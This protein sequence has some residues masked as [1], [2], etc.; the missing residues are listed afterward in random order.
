MTRRLLSAA[1]L[2]VGVVGVAG[3][4]SAAASSDDGTVAT[5]GEL[6]SARHY[7]CLETP[8]AIE[9]PHDQLFHDGLRAEVDA[10]PGVY[11]A[12]TGEQDA[13]ALAKI[14]SSRARPHW[15]T[16]TYVLREGEDGVTVEANV[17]VG[18][19]PDRAIRATLRGSAR[20]Q[21]PDAHSRAIAGAIEATLRRLP[22]LLNVQSDPSAY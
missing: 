11:L 6:A 20:A 12:P 10:R 8:S 4:G 7:V 17:I 21:G 3:C 22:D 2:C 1:L 16:G 15:M 13:Q 18:T 19:F 9:S 5:S 14:Q